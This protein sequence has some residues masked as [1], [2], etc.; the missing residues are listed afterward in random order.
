MKITHINTI[1]Q[2]VLLDP[3]SQASGLK[4]E[5]QGLNVIDITTL[6]EVDLKSM[7]LG[8]IAYRYAL[9]H[10]NTFVISGKESI[11]DPHNPKDA[12]GTGPLDLESFSQEY[13]DDRI[14]MLLLGMR[15]AREGTNIEY[16]SKEG[17]NIFRDL[18]SG[19]TLTTYE[20]PIPGPEDPTPV[21]DNR[22][23]FGTE[24]N[25]GVDLFN[26][27]S[28]NDHVYGGD[29]DDEIAGHSGS[30]Y[31]EGGRGDDTLYHNDNSNPQNDDD[32]IDLLRGGMGNDTYF[33]GHGDIIED[34]DPESQNA[35]IQFNGID[36]RG[37]YT[38]LAGNVYKNTSNGLYLT[39]SDKD[40]SI[41]RI[42]ADNNATYITLLNVRVAGQEF[43]NGDYGIVLNGQP[44]IP[45]GLNLIN[46]SDGDDVLIGT[47][48]DDEIQGF[49]G[50]DT[51]NG[52]DGNDLLIGG[53]GADDIQGG[54]GNDVIQAGADNDNAS[55]GEGD[56]VIQG[57]DGDDILFGGPGNDVISGE[58]GRD[59]LASTTGDD[60]FEGGTGD[61][62]ISGGDDHDYLSGGDDNDFLAGGAGADTLLGGAGD[63]VLSGDGTYIAQDRAW[64]VTVTDTLPG[65]PGGLVV[66][67]NN[68][69]AG[70][71]TSIDD[72]GDLLR[73][74]DGN[75][76]LL[77]G[78]GNDQLF[79]EGD[80]DSLEGEDGDDR[81]EGGTGDD[82]LWG[83]S[84]T[85]PNLSGNDII[86]G[87]VSNKSMVI[88]VTH[89]Q[90]G[91]AIRIGSSA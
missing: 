33:V 32:D 12:S 6:D 28:S 19:I 69:I 37:E 13:L 14:D 57:G 83:D 22:V 2:A 1:Q 89:R 27:S 49:A 52:E 48:L 81:L 18:G 50:V 80:N 3:N 47:G 39:L 51:I 20:D 70:T 11:Y 45:G 10:L 73:G 21:I 65:D 7:A 88:T 68:S 25:E 79:G 4:P 35:L 66:S 71:A 34:S 60:I 85:D 54:M 87:G 67:F 63:D 76:V 38:L 61:D 40:I 59:I 53:S 46:G 90:V 62:F 23:I 72:Q 24:A 82:V 8:S 31:L 5:F 55:G 9:V 44:L 17:S 86:S 56:D 36:I 64:S 15:F 91:G 42:D 78:G 26:T 84:S 43:N 77:G 30:D 58:A 41:R 74:G 29:G 75:D 16:L